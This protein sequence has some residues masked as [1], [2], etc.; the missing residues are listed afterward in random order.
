MV[1]EGILNHSVH[2][3]IW[4]KERVLPCLTAVAEF[5]AI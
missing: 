1:H 4:L 2:L 5:W 3:D